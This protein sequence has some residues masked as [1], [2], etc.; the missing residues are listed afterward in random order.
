VAIPA[1]AMRVRIGRDD[2]YPV[3]R[4]GSRIHWPPIRT[5]PLTLVRACDYQGN[6]IA[7][8][9]RTNH[10]KSI[11]VCPELSDAAGAATLDHR[12]H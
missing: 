11:A 2:W 12:F 8:D 1:A 5:E 3:G 6:I 7:F 4:A 9:R 10:F